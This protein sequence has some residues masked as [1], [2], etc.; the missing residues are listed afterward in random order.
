A[1]D[2]RMVSPPFGRGIEMTRRMQIV[3]GVTLL[4]ASSGLALGTGKDPGLAGPFGVAL[5]HLE[6][7][8]TDGDSEVVFEV[9]AGKVGLAKLAV[10]APDGR[11]GVDCTA[12]GA[13]TLRIREFSFETPEPR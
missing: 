5:V 2:L 9:I 3:T 11:T 7:N 12:P 4:L 1:V 10:V 8:V 6:Q 13:S